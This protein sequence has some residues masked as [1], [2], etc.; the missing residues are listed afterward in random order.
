[1]LLWN[2]MMVP[3]VFR[4]NSVSFGVEVFVHQVKSLM[5]AELGGKCSEP[6][7]LKKRRTRNSLARGCCST[8]PG[9]P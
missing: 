1:M 5:C 4:K 7:C 9:G 3:R 2:G 6:V 8:V